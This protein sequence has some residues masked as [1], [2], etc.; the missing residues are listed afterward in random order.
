MAVMMS[1]GLVQSKTLTLG[2]F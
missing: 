2:I 1:N